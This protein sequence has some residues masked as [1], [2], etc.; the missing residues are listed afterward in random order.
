MLLDGRLCVDLTEFLGGIIRHVVAQTICN[1]LE[2]MVTL[3]MT[4]YPEA[5]VLDKTIKSKKQRH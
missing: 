4:A 3:Y 1:E 5:I 2:P